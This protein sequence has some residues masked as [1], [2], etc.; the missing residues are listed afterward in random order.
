MAIKVDMDKVTEIIRE[1]SAVEIAPRFGQLDFL[2]GEIGQRMQERME[3][4][5]LSPRRALAINRS[6]SSRSDSERRSGKSAPMASTKACSN[7]LQ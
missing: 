2:L 4:V 1:V 5:K 7:R 6:I 3:V